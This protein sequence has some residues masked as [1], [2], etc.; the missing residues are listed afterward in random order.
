MKSRSIYL[1]FAL[2]FVV[3]VAAAMIPAFG[4]VTRAVTAL[5]AAAAVIAAIFQLVRD[6]AAHDRAIALQTAQNSFAVGATSHMAN[7]AFDKHVAFSEEYVAEMFSTLRTLFREGPTEQALRHAAR[8]NE[9]RQK[10]ALW[11]TPAI[12]VNL[13][14]FEAAIRKIGADAGFVAVDLVH[15]DRSEVI[16]EMYA[17]F[18]EVMGKGYS[19]QPV[20]ADHAIS[21]VIAQ[22]R[23]VLGTDE[24]TELR[25]TFVSG[26]LKNAG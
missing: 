10:W 20:T 22:L 7:V 4:D 14:K 13:D 15:P 5:P 6:Q 19:D 21:T 11:L 2:V 1:L 23:H 16:R 12:E 9:I 17:L 26:S 24:L 18:K 3:F 8:L 25:Q